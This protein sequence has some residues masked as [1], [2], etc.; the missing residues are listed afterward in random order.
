[1]ELARFR[2]S[3]AGAAPPEGASAPLAALWWA[4]KGD[5]DRAHCIVQNE[6]GAASARVHAHLHRIEGDLGNAAYWY[7]RAGTTPA[8]GPLP[9]EWEEIAQSLLAAGGV[10]SR[11]PPS[12]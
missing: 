7:R 9:A 3:L 8:D 1:M 12:A 5:W 2:A 10:F 4:A 11:P 6:E